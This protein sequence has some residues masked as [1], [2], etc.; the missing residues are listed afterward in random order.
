MPALDDG[1]AETQLPT[2]PLVETDVLVVGTG[3]GG[4][5]AALALATLGVRTIVVSK[6]RWTANS[7]RAHLTNQRAIEVFRDLGIEDQCRAAASPYELIGDTIFCTSLAGDEL[8]RLRS[9]G[10]GPEFSGDYWGA[11]PSGFLDLPQNRLEPILVRNAIERGADVRFS[12]EYLSLTQDA[13]GVTAR[14]RDR[15]NG[16][17]YDIRAKYM[18]GADGA[19]S[20]VARDIGLPFEGAMDVGGAMNVTFK[21]DLSHLVAHRPAMLY[22]VVQPGCDIGGLGL[23]LVRMV[24]PWNEWL[25]TWGYDI[26]GDPPQLDDDEAISIVRSLVGVPDLEVEILGYSLWGIND[27]HAS[28]VSEGRVFCVGDAI[29]RHPPNHGLGSNT[30]LQDS[31]NL[32]WKL[33]AVLNGTAGPEL[34]DTYDAERAPVAAQIVRRANESN[35]ETGQLVSALGLDA[36]HSA[37]AM[38][39][40]LEHRLA[41]TAAGAAQREAIHQGVWAK[42]R[43]F[44]ANGTEL[45]QRYVSGAVVPEPFGSATPVDAEP[46]IDPEITY[47]PTTTPGARLPHAWV[48]NSRAT[49]TLHDLVPY[50]GFAVIT[51]ITGKAWAEAAEAVAQRLGVT[52]RPIVIG[53]GEEV[54]DLYF[55]WTRVNEIAEDG[56]VLVRPDKHV[57]FRSRAMV[58]N[59]EQVLEDALRTVLHRAP[60]DE[61]S[62]AVAAGEPAAAAAPVGAL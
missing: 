55:T 39:E 60:S 47:R 48:G 46:Q 7:P 22:W 56:V 21:A 57:A 14:V 49:H 6:Y 34:L 3:P 37:E 53:P 19:R 54:S 9:W 43:E 41:P 25:I 42:N 1:I 52:V 44:N 16:Y 59:P 26:A 23:G 12:T 32:V 28:R 15:I 61:A 30:S 50:D 20:K 10:S 13:D 45:G 18:I 35:R 36:G 27:M 2:G 33:A 31:Y 40:A 24:Q 58:E 4:A 5:T 38:S 11:S 51:G 62:G 29:H 17:E 8:G